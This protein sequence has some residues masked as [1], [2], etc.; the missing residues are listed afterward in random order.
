MI[1]DWF[2]SSAKPQTGKKKNEEIRTLRNDTN[3]KLKW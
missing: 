2:F 1:M 3:F